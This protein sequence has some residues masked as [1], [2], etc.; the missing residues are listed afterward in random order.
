MSVTFRV[1]DVPRAAEPLST[2]PLA[3]S[4]KATTGTAFT[5]AP[6]FFM[7]IFHAFE[8]ATLFGATNPWRIR[9]PAAHE[10]I[11][12]PVP[13]DRTTSAR[14]ILDLPDGT[15]LAIARSDQGNLLVRGRIDALEPLPPIP[16]GGDPYGP[17]SI[18]V[19]PR[20]R[21]SRQPSEEVRIL[22]TPLATVLARALESGGSTDLP[23][24]GRLYDV[25][26]AWM[27]LP[28]PPPRARKKNRRS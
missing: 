20:E 26:P 17:E 18:V 13:Y 16:E 7:G 27:R 24:D 28:P 11:L 3:E 14:R 10:N 12:F 6:A 19:H 9:T 1:D 2:R 25:L 22:R 4:R 8:E 15:F 23:E 21:R 5:R